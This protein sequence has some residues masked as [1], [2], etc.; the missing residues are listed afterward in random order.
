MTN[1]NHSLFEVKCLTQF[2]ITLVVRAGHSEY[3]P[4]LRV[5]CRHFL[6]NYQHHLGQFD[7]QDRFH[8][9]KKEIKKITIRISLQFMSV[10]YKTYLHLASTVGTCIFI[11][12]CMVNLHYEHVHV[13][14][15]YTSI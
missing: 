3:S 2:A 5:N 11:L 10:S 8:A 15:P 14:L 13:L 9:S 6:E 7:T 4:T 12:Q 1:N